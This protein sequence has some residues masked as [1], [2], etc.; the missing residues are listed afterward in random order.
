MGKH[1]AALCALVLLLGMASCNPTST[2]LTGPTSKPPVER[3]VFLRWLPQPDTAGNFEY[4]ETFDSSG[5]EFRLSPGT[6]VLDVQGRNMIWNNQV[7]FDKAGNSYKGY[8][9][10]DLAGN[11]GP[12]LAL[13]TDYVKL[14]PNAQ[15]IAYRVEPTASGP[16]SARIYIINSD[17]T[18]EYQIVSNLDPSS[19]F[20]FSPDG[21]K[22]AFFSIAPKGSPDTLQIIDVPPMRNSENK[23]I[24]IRSIAT[25][26]VPSAP[27]AASS[28]WSSKNVLFYTDSD[29]IFTIN[30][31]GTNKHYVADGMP[32][33]WSPDGT[34]LA[35]T[36]MN[37]PSSDLF[38]TP[39]LG[40]TNIQLTNTTDLGEGDAHWSADA[41]KIIVTG[42]VVGSQSF[43]W[44]L[45]EIDMKTKTVT[46]RGGSGCAFG[47]YVQ[48]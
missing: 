29:H 45:E 10:T 48:Q 20:T 31:D 1:F 37:G 34:M 9:V 16:V 8:E 39:D 18:G 7:A 15:Q 5:K 25:A 40:L 11:H 33:S 38:I 22:L 42:S 46:C 24:G 19:G 43:D 47:Q 26:F 3:I 13:V 21:K 41:S 17:G 6:G 36:M 35:F 4:L 14:S 32:S 2:S 28:F 27:A 12:T 30:S 23:I 44:V